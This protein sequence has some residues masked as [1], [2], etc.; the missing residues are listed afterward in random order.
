M[1][2]MDWERE[3]IRRFGREVADLVA[4]YFGSLESIPITPREPERVPD[5]FG[6]PL[7]EEGADPFALLAEVKGKV[8]PA[9]FHLP[10][11]RYFGLFNPTPTVIGVFADTI[12][13]MINQNMAA[14]S[15]GPAGTQIEATVIRWLCDLVGYGPP[16]FGTLTN[17]GTLANYTGLKV[18]L[19]DRFPGLRQE[20]V[21]AAGGRPS[22]YVSNQAHYSLTRL[23]DLMGIGLEGM[24]AIECDAQARV[25]VAAMERRIEADRAEGW[26]P[27][28]AV[29]IAGTT[30]S[31]AIDPLPAIAGL[32]ARQGLWYHVDAAWGGAARLSRRR[33][34]LLDGIERADSVTLDPHKWFSVPFAA[35]AI[36]VKDG[37]ALRRTFEVK[38]HYVSDRGFTEHEDLNLFQ[39]GVAG[40][41]RLDAL[42]V[43]LSLRQYG[44]RGYEEAV[45]RQVALAE[46][47]AAKAEEAPDLEK[48]TEPSL[49]VVC[50]RCVPPSMK[51]NEAEID[52]LQMRIQNTVERRGRAWISTSVLHGRR[53]IRFC[54]TSYL[55]RERHVDLM[56]DEVRA[57]AG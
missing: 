45:E 12:A 46:Y 1:P 50:F 25:D 56:L 26:K 33:A 48:V 32:C 54:A 18:A 35:G 15:H 10:S 20:G 8:L 13:S 27:F 37:R 9:S 31:G 47:L 30:T 14:W 42:K 7:P 16:A 51:G 40:S 39:Q 49:G 24:R 23:A 4:E 52:A 22:F 53:V 21:G 38:P 5:L 6:G 36:V 55:S 3:E 57:A 2:A 43:W 19:N 29:G 28:C 44:R 17:G 11:P 41:R 34:A